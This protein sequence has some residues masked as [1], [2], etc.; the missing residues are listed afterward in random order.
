M[1]NDLLRLR[2]FP[3]WAVGTAALS[4]LSTTA[5]AG[6][7]NTQGIFD[8]ENGAVFTEGFE[9]AEPSPNV[10][11]VDNGAL[12][13]DVYL[14]IQVGEEEEPPSFP[15]SVGPDEA[16]Y[17]VSTFV[18]SDTSWYPT[19]KVTYDDSP[20]VSFTLA[21]MY[22]TGRMTSDGW[23]ELA[24]PPVSIDGNRGP[25]V[26][27]TMSS[28]DVDMDA[29]EVVLAPGAFVPN[30]PCSGLSA[31]NCAEG[32]FCMHGYCQDGVALVPPLPSQPS[33]NLYIDV[34][35][36]KLN[37]FFGGVA[38]RQAPMQ[39][40]LSTLDGLRQAPDAWA[41]WNGIA[42]AV[43]ELSDTHSRPFGLLDYISRGG[44]AFPVCLVEGD[45]DLSHQFAPADGT[46]SDVLVSHAGAEKNLGLKAGDRIVAVDGQHP[47]VWAKNL[48]GHIWRLGPAN[49][50][51]V[52][53]LLVELLSSTI[54]A[55]ASSIDVI[56]CDAT[57]GTC[58]DLET[59]EVSTFAQDTEDTILP[60]CDNRPA[61]HLAQGNP[62]P[63]THELEDVRFG[64]LEDSAPGEDLYGMIWNDTVWFEGPNPWEPAYTTFRSD[65]KGLILD[66]RTGNG[67]SPEGAAY[68][69]ELSRQPETVSVWSLNTT[70]GLFDQPFTQADGLTLFNLWKNH[71]VR[72]WRAGSSS[73][74]ED[75]RIA[76]LLARDVSGSDF[77]PFGVKGSSNTKLFGRKT[78]GA[79][80]TYMTFETATMFGWRIASGDFMNASGTPQLGSG[81]E[82]DEVMV[83][84][85]SDLIVGKDTVYER[86]LEW[87]RCGDGGCP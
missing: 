75:M 77:F 35:S 33:R 24:S 49:D 36:Q 80:S 40:A 4:S 44:R 64:L 37:A 5:S 21:T 13:G 1:T 66:H 70:L 86:A 10:Q 6:T 59:I 38:S 45:A 26:E 82:P 50:P 76:V 51:E 18:R 55:F 69:T 39:Q 28:T 68:L 41:F 73:P 14:R 79:F 81:V 17:V 78:M 30:A 20:G 34:L 19:I 52:V 11:V 16:A 67:G 43:N 9:D 72:S 42:R 60:K 12:E 53:S 71:P 46:F 84:K 74:R 47:I 31:D 25:V 63:V 2:K 15:L 62:D 87:V 54:P 85:Q 65:A 23:V 22:P 3:W 57:A 8:F 61:Y 7:F 48:V 32:Q 83:P 27:L 56:R 29:L 58:S